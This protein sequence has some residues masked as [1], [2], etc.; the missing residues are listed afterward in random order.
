MPNSTRLY[1]LLPAVYRERDNELGKPLRA[2]LGLVQE[3]ADLVEADIRQL[4]NNFFIETCEPWVIPYLGDLVGTVALFDAS[5]INQPDTARQLF[6]DLTGLSLIPDVSLRARADV[7]KTIYFRRRKGTLPMLEELARD[8]TG[9]SAHAVEFFELLGWTQC[10]RNH[11]RMHSLHA[12]DLRRV[13]TLDR[14]NGAFDEISHTVDVRP[15]GTTPERLSSS[16]TGWYNILNIGFFLWRLGSYELELVQA[17]RD[18]LAVGNYGYYGYHFSPLGQP[19][20]LFTRWRREG[21]EA[22]LATELHVPGPIRPAAFYNDLARAQATPGAGFTDYYG[23]FDELPPAQN[24]TNLPQAAASSFMIL[25]DGV[26]VPPPLVRCLDLSTWRQPTGN[27]VGV[28]VKLGRMA[29]GTTFVPT[30]RV[31]V[32]YHYGFSADLGGGPYERRAWLLRPALANLHIAVDQSLTTPGSVATLNAA[33]AQWVAAGKPNTLI[34]ILDSCTY[35]EALSL[36]PADDRWLVLEAGAGA[37]DS[38]VRPHVQ[39]SM[40]IKGAHQTSSVTLSGLLIEGGI[41]VEGSLGRLRLLHCTLV[42]GRALSNADGQPISLDP[43]LLVEAGTDSAPSNTRLRVEMAFC[44]TGP[45]RIPSHAEGLWLLDSIVDGVAVAPNAQRT[46]ALA[47]PTGGYGPPAWLERVTIFGRASLR[48]LKWAS[49][50]IFT[51]P[52][53]TERRQSGC[54]R[55]SFVPPTSVTPR[56]YRCQPDLEV[57][58]Q[59]EQREK[60]TGV[61]LMQAQRNAVR[62]AIEKWLLPGFTSTRYGQPAYAQLHLTCPRQIATGAEDGSEMGAFCHLKQPQ[63]TA[64]LRLRLEEYLPFGL[65]SGII[66]VT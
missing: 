19:T 47:S 20:P 55:F 6:P 39:G 17:R 27:V 45:L 25:R 41:H 1:D 33:L 15:I 26:I 62:T 56:R 12:P 9:W 4:W 50:V 37:A 29:F 18:D 42:P 46:A 28:D 65:E 43:S 32:S 24:P 22:G 58:T 51:E 2:L 52:V 61:K 8:V 63:R 30:N 59:I 57:S 11:L 10:M 3:Q 35:D 40:T 49:E 23:M 14:L 7:A 21:D 66:Y 13:E 5:R 64:N 60:A 34:S 16:V 31:D 36:E 38:G 48:E 54:V 53:T 44:I